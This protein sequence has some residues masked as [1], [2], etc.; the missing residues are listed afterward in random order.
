LAFSGAL[1]GVHLSRL[2][3]DL[4]L[5]SS[6]EF[7][8]LQLS[9]AYCT[10]SSLMPQKRNPDVAEL[11][12]GKSGRLLGNL[13][14]L[15]SLLKGLPSGYNRDLQ[16][17]K[18]FLFDT[19]DT[20]HLVLPPLAGAMRTAEFRMEPAAGRMDAALFATDLADYL[21]RRGV[22]FRASHDVVGR[23]VKESEDRGEPLDRLP[24]SLFQAVHPA[25]D[26]DV[27]K[28]FSPEASVEARAVQ[29]GTARDAVLAQLSAA[30]EKLSS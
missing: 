15:L 27:V 6:K 11:V 21:V 19:M 1:L 3:E 23:V 2:G 16:E 9:E 8:Y 17:D 10:G 26:S 18:E 25:F 13:E 5:F 7:G 12:R 24:L 28:V 30:K 29:G 4:V 20:L 14:G 22:P